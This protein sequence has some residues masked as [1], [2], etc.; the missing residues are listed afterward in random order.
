[1]EKHLFQFVLF[2]HQYQIF[3]KELEIDIILNNIYVIIIERLLIIIHEI[4]ISQ[5]KIF[6][7]NILQSYTKNFIINNIQYK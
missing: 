6:S 7:F 5:N 1:M 4:K 2:K 3:K